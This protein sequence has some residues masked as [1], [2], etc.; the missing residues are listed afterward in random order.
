MKAYLIDTHLPVPRSRSSAKIKV[1]YQGHVSQKNGCFGG[2]SVPQT[3]LVFL[4]PEVLPIQRHL[5]PAQPHL[6]LSQMTNFKL[7]QTERVC[8]QQS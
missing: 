5:I 2:I 8:R 6:T 7:F 1:K 4:F 3:H